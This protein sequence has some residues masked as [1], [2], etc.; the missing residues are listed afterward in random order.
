MAKGAQTITPTSYD[1]AIASIRYGESQ[2]TADVDYQ[3]R[4]GK[5]ADVR[6]WVKPD[7]LKLPL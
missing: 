7:Y 3:R 2:R 5:T 6:R 1:I 4:T